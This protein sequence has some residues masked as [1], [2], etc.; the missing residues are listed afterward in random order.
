M[1]ATPH[2]HHSPVW[3]NFTE[4]RVQVTNQLRAHRNTLEFPQDEF[5][6]EVTSTNPELFQ[7][8]IIKTRRPEL[9]G[10]ESL[11]ITCHHVSHLWLLGRGR[12]FLGTS[13]YPIWSLANGWRP[14]DPKR[15]SEK[16]QDSSARVLLS[17][18]SAH[19]LALIT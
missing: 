8:S 18:H 12:N 13:V 5:P 1:P 4:T 6:Q 9:Q 10:R 14:P 16:S 2:Y 11:S 17:P 19:L 7:F 3:G 15:A